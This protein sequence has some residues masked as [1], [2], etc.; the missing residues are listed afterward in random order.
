MSTALMLGLGAGGDLHGSRG[1][2]DLEIHQAVAQPG[3]GGS[4]WA[5]AHAR[6][7]AST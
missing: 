5:W 7:T 1:L 2:F 3:V 4:D 6:D